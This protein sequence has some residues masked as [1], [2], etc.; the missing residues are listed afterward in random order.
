MQANTSPNL[1]DMHRS[2][3]YG[4]PNSPII[5]GV[6]G[7]LASSVQ[8]PAEL[9][10]QTVLGAVSTIAQGSIDVEKLYGG[11]GPTSL[12]LCSVADSGERKTGVASKV[13]KPIFEFEQ[14][15]AKR[16]ADAESRYE[17]R[18][19]LFKENK[20]ELRKKFLRATR[21][22]DEEVTEEVESAL[23][24]L[25]SK[26][27]KAPIK[28]QLVYENSTPESLQFE[29]KKSHG[30]AALV[31]NEGAT[32]LGGP[33]VRNLPFLNSQWSGESFTVNRKTVES[34]VLNDT[35]LTLSISIQPSAIEDFMKKKGTE[36][37]GIG[38]LGRFIFCHPIT[39]QGTRFIGGFE[40]NSNEG[41]N[42]YYQRIKEMLNDFRERTTNSELPRHVIKFSD[43]ARAHVKT[44]YNEIEAD[45]QRNGRFQF[46][47]DH[48][49]KLLENIGRIAA[50][51]SYFEYGKEEK[52]SLQT[53]HDA[54][55]IVFHFSGAYLSCFQAYPTALKNAFALKEY[56]QTKRENGERYI[57]KSS[58]RR[59]GPNRLRNQQALTEA[60][61]VLISWNEFS[62]YRAPV[63]GLVFL[64]LNH[65]L[66]YQQEMWDKFCYKNKLS[67]SYLPPQQMV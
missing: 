25:Q 14:Q 17:I 62:V 66:S 31:S 11:S 29:M 50:L 47:K 35:R 13:F 53:L 4:L 67:P 54:E 52:I 21:D 49:N 3:Q 30:N 2:L 28:P 26:K 38:F 12:F 51:L 15:E 46:A 19:E 59:S 27:P 37:A 40:D 9:I 36:A 20:K 57:T 65:I 32:V 63:S 48:G 45:L 60:M 1:S 33:I 16:F 18:L 34:F 42:R 61:D 22:G 24:D 56:C 44:L 41:L 23:I 8:A 39:T 58:I 55:R 7:S 10:L 64:D 5:S 6:V 43:E